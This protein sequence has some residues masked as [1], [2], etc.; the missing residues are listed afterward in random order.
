[1]GLRGPV[2]LRGQKNSSLALLPFFSD[3]WL[4]GDSPQ[5]SM[6]DWKA[7]Q[8][9]D[10]MVT[11]SWRAP[12]ARGHQPT[13]VMPARQCLHS[14]HL[15]ANIIPCLFQ[16]WRCVFALKLFFLC[17]AWEGLHKGGSGG[18]VGD[19]LSVAG[20]VHCTQETGGGLSQEPGSDTSRVSP[21][22]NSFSSITS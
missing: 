16:V 8:Q 10:V 15:N 13:F 5:P 9:F 4:P 19:G 6:S 7:G 14:G 20:F 2:C 12:A 11:I 22:R 17:V 18:G 21:A 1:M 3:P